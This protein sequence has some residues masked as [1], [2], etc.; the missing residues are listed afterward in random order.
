MRPITHKILVHQRHDPGMVKDSSE[1]LRS[2]IREAHFAVAIFDYEG[3]GRH[4]GRAAVEARVEGHLHQNGWDGRAAAIA[5]V[6]EL[7]NWLGICLAGDIS[8]RI[9]GWPLGGMH[10]REFF[11]AEGSLSGNQRQLNHPKATFDKA[12]KKSRIQRSS[13]LYYELARSARV[14]RC[15]DPSFDKLRVILQS[16][17]PAEPLP[18]R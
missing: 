12:L 8:E 18:D 11:A 1:L 17:F 16:W 9:L 4:D 15:S 14:D 13:S 7:E 3:C 6:P 10:L 2:M 5:I